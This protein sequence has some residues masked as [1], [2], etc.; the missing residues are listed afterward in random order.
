M[1]NKILVRAALR[2]LVWILAREGITVLEARAGA[3]MA[4]HGY[5]LAVLPKS[6]PFYLAWDDKAGAT[7]AEAL[8]AM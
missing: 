6:L 1:L 2:L 8:K 7:P 4:S 3:G 5:R